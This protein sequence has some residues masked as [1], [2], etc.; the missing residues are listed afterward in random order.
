MLVGLTNEQMGTWADPAVQQ[1]ALMPIE[2]GGSPLSDALVMQP[3][4]GNQLVVYF[5]ADLSTACSL[6]ARSR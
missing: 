4:T 5:G 3:F 1:Q 2:Q 6:T